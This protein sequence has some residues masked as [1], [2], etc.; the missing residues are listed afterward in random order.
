MSSV[1]EVSVSLPPEDCFIN[2][3]SDTLPSDTTGPSMTIN[4]STSQSQ[5]EDPILTPPP[6]TPPHPAKRGRATLSSP[7][8]PPAKR[9]RGRPRVQR[10]GSASPPLPK[11][12]KEGGEGPR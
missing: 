12:V 10:R 5:T 9:G 7:S 3:V 11:E 8:P 4:S 6:C 1:F 2:L